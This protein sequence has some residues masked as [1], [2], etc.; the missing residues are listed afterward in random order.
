M[1]D[2]EAQYHSLE[3]FALITLTSLLRTKGIID[4]RLWTWTV[5]NVNISSKYNLLC[6]KPKPTLNEKKLSIHLHQLS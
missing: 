5:R 4:V 2:I 3:R 6:L 1:N